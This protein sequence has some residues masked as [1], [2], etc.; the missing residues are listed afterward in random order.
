MYTAH[1]TADWR[2]N[3]RQDLYY[4]LNTFTFDLPPL[5]QRRQDIPPLVHQFLQRLKIQV[6]WRTGASHDDWPES[7]IKY[8]TFAAIAR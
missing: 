7:G 5:S 8:S 2:G 3:F 6:V 1:A 4:R